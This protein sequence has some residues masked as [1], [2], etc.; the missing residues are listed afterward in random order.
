MR[1]PL[2]GSTP[3]R[4]YAVDGGVAVITGAA[5]GIGAA[6]ADGLASRGSHLALVDKDEHGLA[7]VRAR[8]RT[9]W[10]ALRISIHV[11]DL[12][13]VDGIPALADEVLREHGAVTLLINNAG[14]ALGGR[15][16][17]LSLADIDWVMSVNFRAV[18]ALT[19][20]FLPSLEAAPGSHLVNVS[21]LLGLMALPG[22]SAYAASK[23]AVRGFTESLRQE[24]GQ[25]GIG[26][27]VVHPGGV[28]TAIAANARVGAALSEAEWESDRRQFEKLLT[29]DP[30]HAAEAIITGIQ[31][32]RARLVIGADAKVLDVLVRAVPG[33]YATIIN[34][35]AALRARH[36]GGRLPQRVGERPK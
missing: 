13:R 36:R 32:R 23:F 27:T 22:S 8:L 14:V 5:S 21:S 4:D 24:L 11:F 34:K 9:N 18:V 12:S 29:M 26:V 28:R 20:A 2:S 7:R 16:N 35:L 31:K 10:P 30:R 17:Q 25:S 33:S 6:L 1:R 15:F 3:V 19:Q